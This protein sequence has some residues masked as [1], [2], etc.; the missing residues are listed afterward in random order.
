MHQRSP[1]TIEQFMQTTKVLGGAFSPDDQSLVFTTNETGVFNVYSISLADE[2]RRQ[3]THSSTYNVY[4]LSYFPYDERILVSREKG[5][6]E[7]YHLCVLE[8]SG[9]VLDLT[10]GDDVAARFFGPSHD[11]SAFYCATNERD[12]HC[13][14]LYKID[15]GTLKRKLLFSATEAHEFGC[16]SRDEKYI[17]LSEPPTRESSGIFL[18]NT[19]SSELRRLTTL[20]DRSSFWPSCFDSNSEYLYYRTNK[21]SEFFFVERIELATGKTEQIVKADCNCYV[22]F[23]PDWKYQMVTR[24]QDSLFQLEIRCLESGKRVSFPDFPGEGIAGFNFSG[25]GKRLA[26]YVKGDRRPGD[27][28]VY[29]FSTQRAR[30]LM[31]SLTAEINS[32]DLAASETISYH[33]F[34]GLE[35]PSVLWKPNQATA[36]NK[37]PALI[38]VHGGPGGQTRKEYQAT[39]QFLVNHGYAVLAPNYRGSSGYGKT[40]RALDNGK[41][42]QDPLRDC[43]EA[44]RFLVS[45]DYVES[46]KVGIMG[47]SYG[48]FLTL[49]ALTFYP[50]QFAVGI[51]LFGPSNWQRTLES[52]PPYWK[53]ALTDFYRKI[54]DPRTESEI[55]KK[56]SPLFHADRITRPLLVLQGANDPRVLKSESDE[57]VEAIRKKNGVVEY[58]VFDDEGHGFTKKTNQMYANQRIVE[59]LDR[60]LKGNPEATEN[61]LVAASR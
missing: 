20:E 39:I 35:I 49:S 50:Q 53:S 46:S 56:I 30:K 28:Y 25:S 48:G 52:F 2:S 26:F 17:A 60:Y 5:G 19:W 1:Y 38:Y 10:P 41:H 24:D 4:G 6:N 54:G 31:G 55:L 11:G 44:G 23:S 33:S 13:L 36:L 43:I 18:Y 32:A 7:N 14:D 12:R 47:A 34:D 16:I 27:L 22:S 3:L 29:D 37:V 59:F 58:V 51:D 42:A 40:F 9:E 15:F 21:D 57:I 8:S 61:G 45:L